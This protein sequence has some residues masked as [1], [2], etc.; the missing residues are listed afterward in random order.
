MGVPVAVS[1]PKVSTLEWA[2]ARIREVWYRMRRPFRPSNLERW[3]REELEKAGLFDHDADYGPGSIAECVLEL[4]KT[5]GRQ[6]HSGGSHDMT[7][8]IF[9]E[10]ANRRPLTPI[11]TDPGEWMNVSEYSGPGGSPIYQNRR[12]YRCFTNDRTFATHYNV[13]EPG[14]PERV[15]LTPAKA[16]AVRDGRNPANA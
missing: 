11:T 10:L 15:T 1:Q 5:L 4:C 16:R 8:T 9:T 7:L 2:L 14:R 13:D 6:G 3:A 12:D